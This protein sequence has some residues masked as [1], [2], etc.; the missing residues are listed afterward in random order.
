MMIYFL[1]PISSNED[2]FL[3]LIFTRYRGA[4]YSATKFASSNLRK[5][6]FLTPNDL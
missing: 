1:L 6:N 4:Q 5:I 3:N 2:F